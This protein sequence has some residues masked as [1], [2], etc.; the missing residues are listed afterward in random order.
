[1]NKRSL[2]EYRIWKAMKARCYSPSNKNTGLYQKLG[3]KVCDRW[4]HSF[5]NFLEDMGPIPSNDYSIERIDNKKDYCPENC[6]WIP[7]REQPK[8][9]TNVPVYTYKGETHCL[10]EWARILNL[11]KERIRGRIRRGM[12]FEEAIVEDAFKRQI[13]INGEHKTVKE[14]CD[15]FG[16][17][18]GSVYSRIHRGA[19]PVEALTI[20]QE[21]IKIKEDNNND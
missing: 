9:R 21:P 10:A 20:N 3:I 13:T 7:L 19:S 15:V 1:M 14:W 16:L 17:N 2:K 12:S 4:L 18:A 6:K 8:N 11:N 5:D